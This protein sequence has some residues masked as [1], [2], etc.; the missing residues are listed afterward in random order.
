MWRWIDDD[1]DDDDNDDD[2]NDDD[3]NSDSDNDGYN[4]DGVDDDGDDDDDDGDDDGADDDDD[5]DDDGADDDDGD[6]DGDDDSDDD[7]DDDDDNDHDDGDSDN[8]YGGIGVDNE[9][10]M[11]Y[12][13]VFRTFESVVK[14][15]AV[16]TQMKP[17]QQN[18]YMIPFVSKQFIKWNFHQILTLAT[19]GSMKG[20]PVNQYF[21]QLNIFQ[22]GVLKINLNA[23]C[24]ITWTTR[25]KTGF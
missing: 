10:M 19:F 8:H 15:F 17:L 21:D 7:D 24:F 11:E 6:D 13:N 4:D 2:G 25:V 18:F 22:G 1:D 5:G 23:S 20:L 12:C 14:S 3:D 9:W 16:A